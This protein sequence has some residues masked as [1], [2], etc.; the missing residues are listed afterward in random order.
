MKQ[1][2]G[3]LTLAVVVAMFLPGAALAVVQPAPP[4]EQ[5]DAI[6][7]GR[8]IGQTPATGGISLELAVDVSIYGNLPDASQVTALY[9]DFASRE[10]QFRPDP[11]TQYVF[12]L[13][14]VGT[15]Y[16]LMPIDS[17]RLHLARGILV[18]TGFDARSL[19]D[20]AR[21]KNSKILNIV[22][23]HLLLTHGMNSAAEAAVEFLG[24][25]SSPET[26]GFL[27]T[28]S[29]SSYTCL[30][31]ASV[32]AKIVSGD[33]SAL[34]DFGTVIP[35]D[36]GCPPLGVLPNVFAAVPASD[37]TK[38]R[39]LGAFYLAERHA[40]P[41][42]VRSDYNAFEALCRIHT[43]ETVPF[44][45]SG[46]VAGEDPGRTASATAGLFAFIHSQPAGTLNSEA[47][48]LLSKTPIEHTST[49]GNETPNWNV[50][51]GLWESWYRDNSKLF[52]D[53]PGPNF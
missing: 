6:F 1:F 26:T 5:A 21:D 34:K 44:L 43:R 18:P 9:E 48:D 23:A 49:P 20:S 27:S 22:E 40:F 12:F 16:Q 45:L 51:V 50:I 39:A 7:L 37:T 35:W 11:A 30:V 17:E 4:L 3:I 46:L 19:T 33:F 8:Q 53:L 15:Q 10:K 24:S 29:K 2:A 28:L 52:A 42:S 47:S 31:A 14:L 32:A 38:V 41:Q 36:S 13:R 25:Y